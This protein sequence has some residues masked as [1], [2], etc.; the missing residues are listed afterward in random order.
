[1]KDNELGYYLRILLI[2]DGKEPKK[3][4]ECHY[5]SEVAAYNLIKLYATIVASLEIKLEE[6]AFPWQLTGE[7]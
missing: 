4:I 3:L 5:I 2:R 7:K 6:E 1:M